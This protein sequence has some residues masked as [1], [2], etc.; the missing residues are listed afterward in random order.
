MLP[1]TRES[2]VP[3]YY[4][5]A[6]HLRSRILAREWESGA[7]IT[8]EETLATEY[9]VSRVTMR[10]ALAELVKDGL[11]ARQQGRGTFVKQIPQPLVHN[12][13]VPILFAGQ[14]RRLGHT[15][16]HKVLERGVFSGPQPHVAERLRLEPS[17]PV[18]YLKRLLLI[19]EQPMAVNRSWFSEEQVPGIATEELVE[20]SLSS[21]LAKRYNFVPVRAEN[22][23]EVARATESEARWLETPRDTPLLILTSTSFLDADIPLEYSVTAWLGDNIRFHFEVNFD[24]GVASALLH[25]EDGREAAIHANGR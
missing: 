11:L 16:N 5:I 21:T 14:L 24:N 1:I 6:L 12:F 19:D 4:Q 20:G 7:R 2:P 25:T 18:A 15:L 9:G 10:Q 8:P 22:L 17:Q 23:I 13:N 3:V